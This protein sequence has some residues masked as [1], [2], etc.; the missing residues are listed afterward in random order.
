[1]FVLPPNK[2][3]SDIKTEARQA[4]VQTMFDVPLYRVSFTRPLAE[5]KAVTKDDLKDILEQQKEARE[6][7]K[8]VIE[9]KIEEAIKSE[10]EFQSKDRY[11]SYLT[12]IEKYGVLP[13]G[14]NRIILG[15]LAPKWAKFPEAVLPVCKVEK[16]RIKIITKKMY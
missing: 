9:E 2:S 10:R 5:E 13:I 1:M 6:E 7:L 12:D 11:R 3:T 4:S 8:K 15:T 16:F 14:N